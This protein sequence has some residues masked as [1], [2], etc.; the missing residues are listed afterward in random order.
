MSKIKFLAF[1]ILLLAAINT[2]AQTPITIKLTGGIN[3]PTGDFSNVY[4]S[5]TSIEGAL[6]YSLP[7]P[8]LDLTFTAGY[9]GYKYKNEYFTGL[10]NTN[11]GVG[12]DNFNVSWTATDIP[13]M[14]G[15]KFQLP[16]GNI[17]PYATGEVG[18]HFMSFSDR[19]NGQ[20]LTGNTNNPTTF[21]FNG[22]TESGSETG[23]GTAIGAGIEIPVAP[24]IYLDLNAKYNYSTVKYSKSFLVF[25]NSNSQFVTPELKN[26]NYFTVR[27]GIVFS[28]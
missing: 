2:Y 24:K 22:S 19:F 20:K 3:N 9:N 13:V 7:V 17:K 18:V 16:S 14:I 4:K 5:G 1:A 8:G 28:L 12:V 10:V 26:P 27:G 6:Y 21:S 15:A 25:R 23:F 11:L